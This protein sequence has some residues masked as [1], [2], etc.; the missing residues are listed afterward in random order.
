M[1]PLEGKDLLES[2]DEIIRHIAERPEEH[3]HAPDTMIECCLV[4]THPETQRL[5]FGSVVFTRSYYLAFSDPVFFAHFS[6][7]RDSGS[8]CNITSCFCS[9]PKEI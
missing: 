8:R 1:I 9:L 2:E 7:V 3:H 4:T 6:H 5:F